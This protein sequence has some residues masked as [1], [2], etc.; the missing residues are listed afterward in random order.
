MFYKLHTSL[1]TIFYAKMFL[2]FKAEEKLMDGLNKFKFLT[3]IFLAMFVFII[4]AIYSNTRDAS[5]TKLQSKQQTQTE[6]VN[7]EERE[8][9]EAISQDNYQL[10]DLS[11]KVESLSRRLDEMNNNSNNGGTRM[12]C[13]VQGVLNGE[14][15]EQ[16]SQDAAIQEARDNGKELVMICSF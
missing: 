11:M 15:I 16:L 3:I 14:N 6:H 1:N 13:S 9:R 4:A 2:S 10:E 8:E 7:F 12:N 5:E